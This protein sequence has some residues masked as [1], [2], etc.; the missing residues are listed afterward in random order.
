ML[1]LALSVAARSLFVALV[2]ALARVAARAFARSQ[3]T[4][5]PA[6]FRHISKFALRS[7]VRSLARCWLLASLATLA[8]ALAGCSIH[9]ASRT[10]QC[11]FAFSRYSPRIPVLLFRSLARNFSVV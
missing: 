5:R 11:R 10:V 8:L 4:S 7:F 6:R 2:A 1:P 9:A 3:A